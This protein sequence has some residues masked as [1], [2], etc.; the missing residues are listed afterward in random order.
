MGDGL[1]VG[2]SPAVA[3]E[4]AWLL[5]HRAELAAV[6]AGVFSRQG[7]GLLFEEGGEGPLRQPAGGGV[8]DLLQGEQ[9]DVQ[10][11]ALVAEGTAGHDFAPLG[12]EVTDI[13]EFF[14]C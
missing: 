10:A 2:E 12:G 7:V 1:G 8:G 5:M 6:G 9:V 4:G 14:R 3:A 11:G 13:L